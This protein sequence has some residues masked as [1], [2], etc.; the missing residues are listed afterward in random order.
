MP[1]VLILDDEERFRKLLARMLD[2]EGYEVL[3][4]ANARAGLKILQSQ[5]VDVLLCDVRLPDAYGVDLAGEIHTKYPL[6]PIILLTAYGTIPDGVQAMRL[7]VFDYLVK[8][9]DHHR[10]LPVL[11]KALQNKPALVVPLTPNSDTSAIPIIGDSLLIQKAKNLALK[12]AKTQT[13]VLLT[14][15]TGTGKEVFAQFIHAQSQQAGAPLVAVNCAAIGKDLLESELFGHKAGAFTGATKD[16]KGLLNAADGGTIFLDELGEMSLDLQT[17]L[18]RV[19]ETQTFFAVGDNRPQTLRLRWIAATNR[20]LLQEVEKGNFRADLYYRVSVFGIHLP[21]LRERIADI[22]AL[23]DFLVGRICTNMGLAKFA[24]RADFLE[25]LS[26]PAWKGNIRELKNVLER[27]IILADSP[28]LT[29][30]LLPAFSDA[31]PEMANIFELAEVEKKHIQKMLAYTN[32]NKTETA[33]LL[34]IGL[35]TLYR[36]IEIYK[37]LC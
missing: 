16:K 31:D 15:E 22:P 4:A 20:D 7:G 10:I 2:L 17:K 34:G 25:N 32:Q 30:D 11:E 9:D 18:L 36:K 24:M 33:R 14:G 19:L 3:E 37:I 28:L 8:G 21:A 26:K 5:P 6:L 35:T 29:P 1:K 27:A 13:T 12:V 23:A